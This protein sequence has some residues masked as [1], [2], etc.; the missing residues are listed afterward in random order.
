MR[1]RLTER[2]RCCSVLERYIATPIAPP[3][4]TRLCTA[5]VLLK[6]EGLLQFGGNEE[7]EATG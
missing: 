2:C 5:R 1:I 3:R 7:E 6:R 4:K